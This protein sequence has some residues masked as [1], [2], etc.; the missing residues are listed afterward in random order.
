MLNLHYYNSGGNFYFCP[1][2]VS[3]HKNFQITILYFFSRYLLYNFAG[4]LPVDLPKQGSKIFFLC[5]TILVNLVWMA[6]NI[7]TMLLAE[8]SELP[9]QHVIAD[10][11][12]Q[13]IFVMGKPF[14]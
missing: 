8:Y 3:L 11:S 12:T 9:G 5:S 1:K 4:T 14:H 7:G 10:M 2:W 6:G 13:Y